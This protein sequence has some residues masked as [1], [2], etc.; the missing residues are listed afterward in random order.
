MSYDMGKKVYFQFIINF[1][2]C[3]VYAPMQDIIY[4]KTF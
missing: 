1:M 2:I 4:K 3:S